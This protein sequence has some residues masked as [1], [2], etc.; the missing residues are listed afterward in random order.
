MAGVSDSDGRYLERALGLAERGRG[1]T[2]PNPLVG[3]VVVAGGQVVGEGFHEGPGRD[4][5]EVAALRVAGERARDAT[6][7]CTLE[8]CCHQGRT[9]PC[10]EAIIA[11]GVRRVVVGLQDPNPL[12]NGCGIARL[13]AAGLE[14]ELADGDVRRRAEEQN[15]AFVHYVT[16]GLPLVTYKAAVSLDGKVAAAGGDARWMSSA[17]S[18]RRV[19]EL[20]ARADAV[21]VGAGTVRRDDPRLTV[22][23]AP[24]RDPVRVVLARLGEVPLE[25]ALVRTALETPT[26]VVAETI[27]GEREAALR[28]RGVEVLVTGAAGPR[29]ALA[30]LAQRGLLDV[31][32]EGG[33]TVAAALLRDGLVEH[34]LLFVAPLL[35]G[36]GAPDLVALP[37]AVTMGEVLR[38]EDV[39][40]EQVGADV[41]LR[42]R[43]PHTAEVSHQTETAAADGPAILEPAKG[44]S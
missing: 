42:A 4:H 44:V 34:L 15:E 13:R 28:E 10:S 8:P 20:R 25:A 38:L 26:L 29:P 37:A 2:H 3:A 39:S 35:V 40:W 17:E 24:G 6:L 41:L 1:H 30:A 27:D 7:Y 14:V 19:H 11:Y 18:R 33:P 5:A 23:D 36:R 21:L 22:R 16:T 32:F 43:V 31:L 9:P 12:V